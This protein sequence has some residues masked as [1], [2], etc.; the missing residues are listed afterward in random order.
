MTA[1]SRNPHS[2]LGHRVHRPRGVALAGIG[3]EHVP[4][5]G[6]LKLSGS[7]SGQIRVTAQS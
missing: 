3:L 1:A 4:D 2:C 5:E 6:R 7:E